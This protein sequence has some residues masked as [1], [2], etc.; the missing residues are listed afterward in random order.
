MDWNAVGAIGEVGGAIGVIVT[1]IYLA[2]Q[3]R[4]NTRAM[5]SSTY[6]TYSGLAMNISDYLVSAQRT[7]CCLRGFVEL[8]L[9][10][11]AIDVPRQQRGELC[12]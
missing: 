7:T 8:G 12:R 9:E 10:H 6:Q 3:L 5:R 4:Q 11:S 1:L 2:G